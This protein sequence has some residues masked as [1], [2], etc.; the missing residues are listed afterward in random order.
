MEKD[1]TTRE[2]EIKMKSK[3][4][5]GTK[6]IRAMPINEKAFLEEFKM[7]KVAEDFQDREGYMVKYTDGY[8]SWSPKDVFEWAYREVRPEEKNLL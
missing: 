8:I 2:I 4:Y 3:A 7:V 1:P 5:I 6:I